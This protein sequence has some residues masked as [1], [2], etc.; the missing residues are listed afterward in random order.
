LGATFNCYCG[1][2]F[3]NFGAVED[4][5]VITKID[6]GRS[7]GFGFEEMRSDAETQVV[8]TRSEAVFQRCVTAES[9]E[10]T[11]ILGGDVRSHQERDEPERIAR[12]TPGVSH[13]ENLIT[14]TPWGSGPAEEWGY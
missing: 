2:P 5:Q 14:I 11:I 12:A 13:V 9:G 4:A 3:S 8:E 7:K 6:P 10:R 1:N